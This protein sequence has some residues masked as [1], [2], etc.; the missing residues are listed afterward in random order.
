MDRPTKRQ[1]RV[2]DFISDFQ[3]ENGMPPTVREIA[4][5]LGFAS[6]NAVAGHLAA[7]RR[8]GLLDRAPGKSRGIKVTSDPTRRVRMMPVLGRIAAGRPIHAEENVEDYVA[9]DPFLVRGFDDSFVLKVEGD[10][11][12]GDGILPGDYIFVK[13]QSVAERGQIV[14]ALIDDE[15]TIKRYV[16]LNG[17]AVR[18]EA[19]NPA[20]GPID[21]FPES[22]ENL[23]ILGVMTGLYRRI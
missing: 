18:L 22:D 8:K 20:Y 7:L 4:A 1:K 23:E 5:G 13:R 16:P 12:S 15:A 19:S 6:T 14:V 9:A 21:I 2:L 3:L 17:G 10:S 11:M